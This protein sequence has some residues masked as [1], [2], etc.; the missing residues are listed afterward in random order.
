M[1]GSIGDN[2]FKRARE[3]ISGIPVPLREQARACLSLNGITRK[4]PALEEYHDV[5]KRDWV[6]EISNNSIYTKCRDVSG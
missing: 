2:T 4:Y 3:V 1:K 5:E 6:R